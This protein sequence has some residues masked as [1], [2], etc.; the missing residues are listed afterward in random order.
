[1]SLLSISFNPVGPL[2]LMISV[3]ILAAIFFLWTELKRNPVKVSRI[4]AQ[5]LVLVSLTGLLLRPSIIREVK[6]GPVAL[7]TEG[8][9]KNDID[10]LIKVY[11]DL[12]IEQTSESMPYNGAKIIDQTRINLRDIRFVL[13]NGLPTY[14]FDFSEKP[15]YQYLPGTTVKGLSKIIAGPFIL[16]HESVIEGTFNGSKGTILSLFGPGGIEDSVILRKNGSNS[17]S[18]SL[19]PKLSG[20]FI[21]QL[22]SKSEDSLR[23]DHIPVEVHDVR[24]LNVLMLQ[25]FPSSETRAL[26]NF[27]ADNGHGVVLRNRV[28]K[29][30][31]RY[32]FGNHAAVRIDKINSDLLNDFDLLI[33][34]TNDLESLSSTE[35]SLLDQSVKDGLGLIILLEKPIDEKK[36][37]PFLNIAFRKA[38]NDTIHFKFRSVEP[39]ILQT[40]PVTIESS[41]NIEATLSNPTSTLSGYQFSGFGKVGFQSLR[42]TYSFLLKGLPSVYSEIWT[43]LVERT[44]RMENKPYKISLTDSG[45]FYSD[46]PVTF[47]IISGE[48]KPDVE[49]DHIPLALTEDVLIDNIWYGKFWAGSPGWHQLLVQQDS[50]TLNFYVFRHGEN[51]SPSLTKQIDIN[52]RYASNQLGSFT[53]ITETQKI[54]IWIFFAL[55]LLA[56]GYLWL[57]P[58]L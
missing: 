1:M 10:S 31:Y 28:S 22:R 23:T 14:S 39:Q 6:P 35:I 5:F 20:K 46:E 33:L 36:L 34:N 45:P 7:L 57:E 17:F 53:S 25:Q 21:Y 12:R 51:A 8:Y 19:T 2:P 47:Q 41:S 48:E 18:L 42:E 16:N 49:I 4:I 55:F 32:E 26:K 13:G 54:S 37:K 52:A 3:L 40:I 27:L 58:K 50:T 44:A 24:K 43:P 15:D 29:D 9:N 30:F 11:S 56:S 38:A